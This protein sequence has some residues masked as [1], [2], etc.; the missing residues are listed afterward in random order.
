MAEAVDGQTADC[1]R[2]GYVQPS[3]FGSEYTGMLVA[4][5]MGGVY[6]ARGTVSRQVLLD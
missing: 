1:K 4:V 3:I 6:A 2:L 5:T